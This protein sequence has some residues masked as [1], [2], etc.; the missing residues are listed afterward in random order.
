M[1][2]RKSG[3]KRKG[4]SGPKSKAKRTRG[5]VA[6]RGG[7]PRVGPFKAKT[8]GF[9]Q[10]AGQWTDTKPV[11]IR[12]M[13]NAYG[14]NRRSGP[15]RQGGRRVSKGAS[16]GRIEHLHRKPKYGQP[17]YSSNINTVAAKNTK[18]LQAAIAQA[19]K[20]AKRGRRR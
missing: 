1:A 19:V 8:S 14:T 20:D 5:T 11:T 17:Q 15:K 6:A 2:K 10:T 18:L 7:T 13:E 16:A 3:P 12:Q 4:S 9:T